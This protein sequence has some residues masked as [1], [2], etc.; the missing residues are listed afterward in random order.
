M[1]LKRNQVLCIGTI[2]KMPWGYLRNWPVSTHDRIKVR[3]G[4]I[5]VKHFTLRRECRRN[6]LMS[7]GCLQSCFPRFISPCSAQALRD[8][9]SQGPRGPGYHSSKQK[10]WASSTRCWFCRY[11]ECE[12]YEIMEASSWISKEGLQNQAMCDRV[13]VSVG[14]T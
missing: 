7:Q 8:Q 10:T 11:A 12:S 6:T 1:S 5:H 9:C 2:R 13:I 4:E 3:K 14:R